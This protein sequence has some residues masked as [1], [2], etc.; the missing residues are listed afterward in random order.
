MLSEALPHNII[1]F[2]LHLFPSSLLLFLLFVILTRNH[3]GRDKPSQFENVFSLSTFSLSLALLF[4]VEGD[5]DDG[6]TKLSG[7]VKAESETDSP[8]RQSVAMTATSGGEVGSSDDDIT[9]SGLI[10]AGPRKG[11]GG[12]GKTGG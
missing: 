12:G 9:T 8:T 7:S 5:D 1:V 3:E 11:N 4:P 2:F 10:D 6:T